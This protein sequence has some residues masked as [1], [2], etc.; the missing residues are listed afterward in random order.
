MFRDAIPGMEKVFL[1]EPPHGSVILIIG[2]AGTLKSAFTYNLIANN[3]AKRPEDQIG[4]MFVS[5]EETRES[6]MR[7]IKTMGIPSTNNIQIADVAS[8]LNELDP[9]SNNAQQNDYAKL[10]LEK[11]SRPFEIYPPVD[12]NGKAVSKKSTALVEQEGTKSTD[13]SLSKPSI[14]V[15]DSLNAL[16]AMVNSN[17]VSLRK[18][19]ANFMFKLREKSITSFIIMEVGDPNFHRPE[20]FLVDGIIELGML[21]TEPR[22]FKRYIKV[23]KM[24]ATKHSIEPF[25]IEV[26]NDG[27]K[28]VEELI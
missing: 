22:R 8:F 27:I 12:S 23:Q 26:T 17:S 1:T 24:R 18:E 3:I 6:L 9:F 2:S 10:I 19:V 20:H 21:E 15:L 13:R 7:N 28:V 14:F 4:C 5:L 11:A 16:N 25:L